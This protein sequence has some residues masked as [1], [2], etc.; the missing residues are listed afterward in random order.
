MGS[1]TKGL[2]MFRY[3]LKVMMKCSFWTTSPQGAC[4]EALSGTQNECVFH[5]FLWKK[6]IPQKGSFLLWAIF[7]N[8]LPTRDMLHHIGVTVDSLDCVMCNNEGESVDHLFMHWDTTFAVWD[9]FIKAFHISWPMPSTVMQLFEAWNWNVQQGRC[10]EVW[11]L[12]HYALIWNIWKERNSRVHG[13]R[14]KK[15]YEISLLIDVGSVEL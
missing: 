1:V 7:N 3:W 14:P 15:V 5:K 6:T 10:K 12:F 13:G 4:Y 2:E 11:S 9:Y 8:S